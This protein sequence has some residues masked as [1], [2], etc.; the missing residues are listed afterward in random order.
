MRHIN[1]ANKDWATPTDGITW[2]H[3]RVELLMDI[4]DLLREID[5]SLRPLRCYRFQQI[6]N[7]LERIARNTTKRKPK[8]SKLKV[9]A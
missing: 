7:R 9:V 6:P 3:V 1:R 4:R 2:E 5:T 8:Q